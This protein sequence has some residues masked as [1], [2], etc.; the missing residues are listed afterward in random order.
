ML[1]NLT[2]RHEGRQTIPEEWDKNGC[3]QIGRSRGTGRV[4]IGR[5]IGP[6]LGPLVA[7]ETGVNRWAC[8]GESAEVGEIGSVGKTRLSSQ[9]PS[10]QSNRSQRSRS[11]SP[12]PSIDVVAPSLVEVIVSRKEQEEVKVLEEAEEEEEEEKEEEKEEEE[13]PPVPQ[14]TLINTPRARRKMFLARY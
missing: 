11:G 7:S 14:F 3:Y 8:T 5:T 1:E 13:E 12:L 9:A 2:E 6:K 10:M 4:G